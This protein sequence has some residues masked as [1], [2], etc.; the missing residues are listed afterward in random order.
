MRMHHAA[1]ISQLL[2]HGDSDDGDQLPGSLRE[3]RADPGPG[4]DAGRL[5]RPL[6]RP[7]TSADV[8]RQ[9]LPVCSATRGDGSSQLIVEQWH[10]HRQHSLARP[11]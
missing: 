1:A 11:S 2:R 6:A 7:C 9:G 3:C 10:G 8:R 5:E 4:R